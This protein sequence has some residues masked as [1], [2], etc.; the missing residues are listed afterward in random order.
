MSYV[1]FLY[2]LPNVGW[3]E[4]C[5]GRALA[6]PVFTYPSVLATSVPIRAYPPY[7]TNVEDTTV[8]ATPVDAAEESVQWVYF[9]YESK[10]QI[11]RTQGRG[12]ALLLA[13]TLPAAPERNS[14]LCLFHA[15]F[16]RSTSGEL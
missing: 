11:K 3:N 10:G 14:V 7:S 15:H 12:V 1:L 2:V 6:M 5:T 16:E 13:V 8:P 4:P 9:T